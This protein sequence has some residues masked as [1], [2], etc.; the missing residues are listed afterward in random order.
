MTL[1]F[2]CDLSAAS[3]M[4]PHYTGKERDT[5]SGNDYF[6][7]RYYNSNT[8]RF[9][10]PD[11]SAKVEP[12][13]YAKLDNP[14]SL[15]LYS[16]VLNNPTGLTDDDGHAITC[17]A[18]MKNRQVCVD[19]VQALLGD[20]HTSGNLAGYDGPDNPNLTIESDDLSSQDSS[21]VTPNGT[22]VSRAQFD[23]QMYTNDAKTLGQ[24]L[25]RDVSHPSAIQQERAAQRIEPQPVGMEIEQGLSMGH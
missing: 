2:A 15:N 20:P 4:P 18:G 8:G 11:W 9:L 12:V 17:A 19:T 14:Q 22:P 5:E 13:P 25:S 1:T 21:T 24:Q 23:V 7:A 16:Y 3:T 6:D 10:S